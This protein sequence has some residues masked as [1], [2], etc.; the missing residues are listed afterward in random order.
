VSFY[1]GR[2]G[3]YPTVA[4]GMQVEPPFVVGFGRQT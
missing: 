3:V 1:P 2:E 4:A